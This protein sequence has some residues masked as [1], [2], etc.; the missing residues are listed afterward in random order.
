[1]SSLGLV[2]LVVVVDLSMLVGPVS[3]R[4][5]PLVLELDMMTLRVPTSSTKPSSSSSTTASIKHS[6]TVTRKGDEVFFA[7]N[8]TIRV[9]K[10]GSSTSYKLL[11]LQNKIKF[12]IKGIKLNSSGN[13]L[14]VYN[15][16][17]VV[18]VSLPTSSSIA[19][20]EQTLISVR[21]FVISQEVYADTEIL[22]VIWNKASRYDSNLVILSSDGVVRS[23]DPRF[24]LETPEL[25]YDLTSSRL[26]NVGLNNDVSENPVS[27]SFGAT[28]SLCS[29][30]TLYVL[31]REGDVF[32]LY[33]FLPRELSASKDQ[34]E[35]LLNTT[36]VLAKDIET[37]GGVLEKSN[38]VNQLRFV[39]SLWNQVNSSER[40][41]R[42]TGT[43]H[44]FKC[45]DIVSTSLQGP[46]AISPYPEA[47]YEKSATSLTIVDCEYTDALAIGFEEGGY[48]L[49]VPSSELLMKWDDEYNYE[50]EETQQEI[51]GLSVIEYGT[52]KNDQG[53]SFVAPSTDA[54]SF[55][56]QS[57]QQILKVDLT[58]LHNLY[59]QEFKGTLAQEDSD[60]VTP[61]LFSLYKL[62][63]NEQVEA[64][65]SFV[66]E[67]NTKTTFIVTTAKVKSL[68]PEPKVDLSLSE[69]QEQMQ[70][71]S[72]PPKVYQPQL[73]VPSF[74]IQS[75]MKQIKSLDI[76]SP[77]DSRSKLQPTET[78]LTEL[79]QITSQVSSN[80]I[81]YHKVG[82][83]MN[84]KLSKQK[85]EFERQI[86][87]TND[88][89]EKL[90]SLESAKSSNTKSIASYIEKQNELDERLSKL[91][92][93]LK[94]V[95][96]IPLSTEEKKWFKEIAETAR[97]FNKYAQQT[98]Q[99]RKQLQYIKKLLD[100]KKKLIHKTANVDVPDSQFELLNSQMSDAKKY[101]K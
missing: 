44:V 48:L 55:V 101:L 92:E 49:L 83:Q 36:V 47:L 75:L 96:D 80:L 32:A 52:S 6:K 93:S 67:F 91:N 21:S 57:G 69:S 90:Q 59:Q 76:K 40:E 19:N 34:V 51:P 37:N 60:D 66:D 97:N 33:P 9:S 43:N 54:L 29:M 100:D 3:S 12:T 77:A 71:E 38:V 2:L 1:M 79:N 15:E 45:E 27:I 87:E 24:S 78:V 46:F 41:I 13:L 73:G 53:Q 7:I 74:E 16:H 81:N 99:W 85:A 39:V 95:S 14:A 17:N 86:K 68:A 42:A 64:V 65:S 50:E 8:S 5:V 63:S 11:D 61:K 4:L 22:E 56:L 28:D 23:F 70:Q 30:L 94:T 18:I 82:I 31:D 89:T 84:Y 58:K 62:Q 35:E 98:E 10:V 26:R 25:A 88:M 20:K 72:A